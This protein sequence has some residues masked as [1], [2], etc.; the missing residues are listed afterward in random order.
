MEYSNS[1][2]GGQLIIKLKGEFTFADNEQFQGMI[3]LILGST[4]K[5]VSLDFSGLE[6]IDS[7]ALSMLLV[8]RESCGKQSMN[9]SITNST[10]R[11]KEVL[12]EMKFSKFIP[13]KN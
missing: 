13:I 10:G 3:K 7:A 4:L 5:D 6:F 1:T 9:I 11:V 2:S 12:D 8:M